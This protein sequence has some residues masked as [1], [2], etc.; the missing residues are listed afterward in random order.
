MQGTRCSHTVNIITEWSPAGHILP[1]APSGPAA[2]S[3]TPVEL[4]YFID[5]LQ[6]LYGE[7]LRDGIEQPCPILPASSLNP[8]GS[9]VASP[10]KTGKDRL[11]FSKHP[12]AG[13]WCS[14]G[15]CELREQS[16]FAF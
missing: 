6:F 7:V 4:S 1:L 10:T 11:D 12:V 2:S 5:E 14:G 15:W 8:L 9:T 3:L 16:E 13:W